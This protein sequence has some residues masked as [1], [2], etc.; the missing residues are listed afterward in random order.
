MHKKQTASQRN[1]QK[2]STYIKEKGLRLFPFFYFF[3]LF[4]CDEC[5]W[6]SSWFIDWCSMFKYNKV[7]VESF[8]L[9]YALRQVHSLFHSKFS[10]QRD[11]VLPLSISSIR[12]FSFTSSSR[13]LHLLLPRLRCWVWIGYK[14]VL[15]VYKTI[16]IGY[17]CGLCSC[18]RASQFSAL[19]GNKFI[20]KLR[21]TFGEQRIVT[22]F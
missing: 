9:L 14:N 16:T 22:K 4:P 5:L 6:G 3:Y 1:E 2:G 15:T 19:L 17:V 10:T 12:P 21:W 20:S 13:F 7:D 11:L 18:C 8:M